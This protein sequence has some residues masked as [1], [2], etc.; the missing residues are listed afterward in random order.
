M[1]GSPFNYLDGNL[2]SGASTVGTAEIGGSK[3]AS[4]KEFVNYFLFKKLL[5]ARFNSLLR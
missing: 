5:H 2:G 3:R 1:P 4:I